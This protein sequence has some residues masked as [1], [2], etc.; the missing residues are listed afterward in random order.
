MTNILI[1]Q[2]QIVTKIGLEDK[3]NLPRPRKNFAEKYEAKSQ[4]GANKYNNSL[5]KTRKVK[6]S[7]GNY[8]KA[9]KSERES[10]SSLKV[11][12]EQVKE[13]KNKLDAIHCITSRRN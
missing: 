9:Q 10:K 3:R 7:L 2:N 13:D 5:G 8:G 12:G 4:S 11:D 1:N 6:S